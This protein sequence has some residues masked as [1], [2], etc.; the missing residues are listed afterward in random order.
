MEPFTNEAT[1]EV[2]FTQT[3]NLQRNCLISTIQKLPVKDMSSAYNC[4]A[5]TSL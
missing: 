1:N 3:E 5:Q 4:L 2:I